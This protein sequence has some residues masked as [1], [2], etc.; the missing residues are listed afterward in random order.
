MLIKITVND[1][2]EVYLFE[3]PEIKY[4]H[5]ESRIDADVSLIGCT[6]LGTDIDN[7]VDIPKQILTI[8]SLI[9]NYKPKPFVE[10]K[11][12]KD[13]LKETNKTDFD[14]SFLQGKVIEDVWCMDSSFNRLRP[15]NFNR[16]N[17]IYFVIE[18]MNYCLTTLDD[19]D[20]NSYL[21]EIV[22]DLMNL[23][24]SKV[25][26]AECIESDID[27]DY[28]GYVFYK[29]RSNMADVTISWCLENTDWY[30]AVGSFYKEEY[31]YRDY[32]YLDSK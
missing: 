11:L 27:N 17:Y 16:T 18:G 1:G 21:H 5:K 7:D 30:T 20:T 29:I 9:D 2:D 10:V 15:E 31:F 6:I 26:L 14:F 22:G 19:W 13:V 32:Y 28:I 4:K 25:E 12:R 24:G 3:K 23:V 8:V